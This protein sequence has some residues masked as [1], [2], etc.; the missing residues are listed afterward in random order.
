MIYLDIKLPL[1][2]SRKLL[3]QAA[4]RTLADCGMTD[5]N[6]AVVLGGDEHTRVLNHQYLGIDA[7]TDVLSFPAGEIDPETGQRYLGDV[8]ISFTRAVDQAAQ[9]G[10]SVEAE[11]QLLVV[12]GVLHLLGYDHATPAEKDRMWE[13]QGR[14]L[15]GLGLSLDIPEK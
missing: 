11:L 12:H 8:V 10:H 6:L 15:T 7:P 14:I 1:G 3:E 13:I 9:R 2:I 5:A 4:E